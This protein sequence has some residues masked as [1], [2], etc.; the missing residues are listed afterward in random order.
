MK[1][2][3]PAAEGLLADG[4]YDGAATRDLLRQWYGEALDGVMPPPKSAVIRRMI[5]A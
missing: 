2:P 4:A 5:N 1:R 3:N